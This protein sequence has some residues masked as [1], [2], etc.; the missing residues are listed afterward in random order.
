MDLFP[1]LNTFS[2]MTVHSGSWSDASIWN[3]MDADANVYI[4]H[5]VTLSNSVS[6]RNI[7]VTSTGSL[8]F[9]PS[10]QLDFQNV[11]NFKLDIRGQLDASQ[12][13]IIAGAG[14]IRGDLNVGVMKITGKK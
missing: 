7:M 13:T 9:N 2:M 4:L 10:G 3:A 8:S 11:G 1:I 12:G 5:S 14:G 6:Y